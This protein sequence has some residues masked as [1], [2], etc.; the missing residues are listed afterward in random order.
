MRILNTL[1]L[2]FLLSCTAY[3]QTSH[4]LGLYL[5]NKVQQPEYAK[6]TELKGIMVKGNP[7]VIQALVT[8][9]KGVYKYS[10]GD[11]S[12]VAIPYKSLLDFS[13]EPGIERIE[14]SNA[15][16]MSFMDSAR[17]NNN[18]DSAQQGFAPLIH[19]YKGTGVIVG[20]IDG[21]LYFRHQDFRRAN[22]NTRVLYLWDQYVSTAP[23][24]SPY[25]YGSEWDSTAIN[26]G[27]CTHAEPTSDNGHGTNVTGI[28]AGNGSSFAGNAFLQNRYTGTAPDADIIF[29][30]LNDTTSDFLQ[31]MADAVNYIFTKADQLGRP[32]VINT[33]VGTYY[34][35]HDGQDL[36]AQA[37][38]G[39]LTAKNGRV[40]VA[41][42]GN[43][44][45]LRYHLSY[46][47]N[48]TDSLFSWFS[49]NTTYHQV[50][51][52]FWA[53]TAQ[54]KQANFAIGCDSNTPK[55]L[56]RTRYFNVINDFNPSQ[57]VTVQITDSLFNGATKLGIYTIAVTLSGSTYHVEFLINPVVTTNLWRLQ[58]K[59]QGRFDLW[60]NNAA[61]PGTS[62]MPT[63]LPG[64][65]SSP[66]YV[67]PDSFKTIVSSWQCSDKVITVA[68]YANR[69]S[70]LDKD[71]IYRAT[72]NVTGTLLANSSIGPTR[73]GRL[74]PDIAATGSTT[75]ATGDSTLIATL[76]G[77]G[78]GSKV[79]YGS[80]H[81]RNGG[82]SM[83]SPIVAG[84]AALY[85]QKHPNAS[86]AEVKYVLEHTAKIDTFTTHNIPN[87]GWGWGKVNAFEALKYQV[88]YGC[89]DTGSANYNPNANIDT[90]GCIAK[91]YG[92]T[93]TGSINYNAAANTNNGTCIPKV[94]G[95]TDTGSIN[96]NAAAN[97]NNGSCI[98]KVY[99]IT[100]T[101]C[102]N[103]NPAANISSGTCQ[104]VGITEALNDKVSFEVIPNP[105][106]NSATIRIET[107][108]PLIN[109]SVRFYDLL[110]KEIDAI[111]IPSGAREV[112]YKN[113]KLASGVYN[114]AIVSDKKIIAIRKVVAE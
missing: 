34:G 37:I 83:S 80:K 88:V 42:A 97:V 25:G 101:A 33:S 35:S 9:Y 13:R 2:L 57:G 46:P 72:G 16:K 53:D 66:N 95:C 58:T 43:A 12:S 90:G 1:S 19:A 7:T 69:S 26:T 78:Q 84:V 54:F 87:I 24:P 104:H 36:A 55:F 77:A 110:G 93:D 5:Y 41:S 61:I 44:G 30:R 76:I 45:G 29:V 39:M 62:N 70:Y 75:C 4:K 20:V 48:P 40:L 113:N 38:D 108:S 28:A 98:A 15:K 3:A 51:F 50:F 74:K 64:G 91:V 107:P 89:K 96:Y 102:V 11:V 23:S 99:G 81:N 52:D 65:F 60:S 106:S 114:A 10:A 67:F 73:D 6:S 22:G 68:N 21:G 59:G 31:T 103:Y 92:C 56:A 109:A 82:T 111:S 100:D 8:K 63:T 27:Q 105:F 94:Y 79:S 112:V 85:L 49:Y 18:I 14:S 32:C 17:I 71:S 86:Y 47:L